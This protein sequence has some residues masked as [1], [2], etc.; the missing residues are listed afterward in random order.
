MRMSSK[1]ISL[2][3]EA[4]ERLRAAR[5]YP[6]ESFSAVVLRATW[7]ESTVTGEALL[8]LCRKR[9]A[10]FRRAELDRMDALK[11]EDAPAPDKWTTR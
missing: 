4:Y 5:R 10:L 1:T 6:N 11:R 9:G 8:D 2:K 3:E 7:P